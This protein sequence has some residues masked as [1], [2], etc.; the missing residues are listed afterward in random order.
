MTD[1]LHGYATCN[2]DIH[3]NLYGVRSLWTVCYTNGYGMVCV[4]CSRVFEWYWWMCRTLSTNC[5]RVYNLAHVNSF[6]SPNLPTDWPLCATMD[7]DTVLDTFFSY[8]LMLDHE[9]MKTS[10]VLSHNASSNV[11]CLALALQAHN[12]RFAGPGQPEWN[13]ACDLCTKVSSDQNG[14]LDESIWDRVAFLSDI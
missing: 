7:T 9:T 4:L 1:I 5:T 10:L 2:T 11:E 6:I 8:S 3:E 13:H 12:S 14:N